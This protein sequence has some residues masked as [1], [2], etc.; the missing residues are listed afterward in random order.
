LWLATRA[1]NVDAQ[2]E[3]IRHHLQ[4]GNVRFLFTCGY[5]CAWQAWSGIST[6]GGSGYIGGSKS[7]ATQIII[8]AYLWDAHDKVVSHNGNSD[9]TEPPSGAT[10]G[11]LGT[12]HVTG[13]LA[14]AWTSNNP[15]D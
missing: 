5:R 12:V 14:N 1:V 15:E 3:R 6:E 11:I 2:G 10:E 9:R 8:D 7:I 13:E 4:G